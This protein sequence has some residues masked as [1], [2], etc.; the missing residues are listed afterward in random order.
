LR[1]LRAVYSSSAR[2][3]ES[4]QAL[5]T[6]DPFRWPFSQAF[7]A[8]GPFLPVQSCYSTLSPPPEIVE[9]SQSPAEL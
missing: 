3:T 2:P 8:G 4:E 1:F 9:I 6:L 7:Q 5:T